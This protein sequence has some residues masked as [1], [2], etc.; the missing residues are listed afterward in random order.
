MQTS[1][2]SNT[3]TTSSLISALER[4]HAQPV[5]STSEILLSSLF[6]SLF[7]SLS[8]SFSDIPVS[9]RPSTGIET[10]FT[11]HSNP[12]ST[13]FLGTQDSISSLRYINTSELPFNTPDK[14]SEPPTTD[15]YHYQLRVDDQLFENQTGQDLRNHNLL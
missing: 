5:S 2:S 3:T 15:P 8:L 12:R 1:S 9:L 11:V 13:P 10:P 14:S 7:L 6:L 4:H